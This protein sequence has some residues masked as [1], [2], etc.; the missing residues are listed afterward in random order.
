MIWS[1]QATL[2]WSAYEYLKTD[3]AV[4]LSW[5][6]KQSTTK[7]EQTTCHSYKMVSPQPRSTRGCRDEWAASGP[8]AFHLIWQ[9][10]A[11]KA[12]LCICSASHLTPCPSI[13]AAPRLRIWDLSQFCISLVGL[14]VSPKIQHFKC[15]HG[16]QAHWSTE[17]KKR[18]WK[19]PQ[20]VKGGTGGFLHP[21]FPSPFQDWLL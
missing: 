8:A 4:L 13:P 20:N 14:Q 21:S 7:P 10:T 3:C 11:T 5:R 12:A 15:K 1:F 2:L 17:M 19:E 9:I 18:K 16:P 6:R